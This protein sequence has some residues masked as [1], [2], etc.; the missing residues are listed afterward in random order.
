MKLFLLFALFCAVSYAAIPLTWTISG[1]MY[2]PKFD[3]TKVTVK[4]VPVKTLYAGVYN[5]MLVCGNAKVDFTTDAF[6]Y[7]VAF[8]NRAF[9]EVYSTETIN[10]S[11]AKTVS[12]GSS[13]CFDFDFEVPKGFDPEVSQYY[14][15]VVLRN[16]KSS[17]TDAYV[18]LSAV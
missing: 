3:V 18:T 10:F 17:L 2:N 16:G 7:Q 4:D 1:R 11:E 14:V 12:A 13:F 15:E 9:G 8:A 6:A 5:T